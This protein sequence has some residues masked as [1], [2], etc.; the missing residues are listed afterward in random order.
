M[1]LTTKTL[2]F[3]TTEWPRLITL[4]SNDEAR[5]R[6]IADMKHTDAGEREMLKLDADIAQDA[7]NQ[8]ADQ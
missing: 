2:T 6:A 1:A 7:V 3:G 4:L 8:L 5:C